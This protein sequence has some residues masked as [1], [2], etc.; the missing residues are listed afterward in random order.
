VTKQQYNVL[1]S[2]L[3]RL[4]V[5]DGD[6]WGGGELGGGPSGP[7]AYDFVHITP[8]GRAFVRACT[9]PGMK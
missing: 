4:Q 8:L 5:I 3:H 9:P 7:T 6:R 2:D 1:A